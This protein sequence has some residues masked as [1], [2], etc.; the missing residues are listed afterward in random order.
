MT[1]LNFDYGMAIRQAELVEEIADEMSWLAEHKM[2]TA[3]ESVAASWQGE[4]ARQFTDYCQQKQDD[5]ITQAQKLADIAVN[6]RQ[7]AQAI[8]EAEERA[9]ELMGQ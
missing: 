3:I 6:I 4:A 9:K 7:V 2:K 5:I 1:E 8:R